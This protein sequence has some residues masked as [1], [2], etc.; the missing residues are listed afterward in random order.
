MDETHPVA[1]WLGTVGSSP[2]RH[3]PCPTAP[4]HRSTRDMVGIRHW[5]ESATHEPP[6]FK[7]RYQ[8]LRYHSTG[9]QAL[10]T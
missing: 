4:L 3:V 7:G 9:A 10:C 5:F 6:A 1:Q 2:R 8:V